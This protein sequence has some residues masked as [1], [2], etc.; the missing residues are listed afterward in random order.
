MFNGSNAALEK[1]APGSVA[2]SRLDSR[3]RQLG[4]SLFEGGEPALG[5]PEFAA[6]VAELAQSEVGRLQT[7]LMRSAQQV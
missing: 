3:V 2:L 1:L 4:C 5:S 6:A 7:S